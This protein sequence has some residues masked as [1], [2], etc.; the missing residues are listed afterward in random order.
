MR[1]LTSQEMFTDTRV[2]AGRGVDGLLRPR[3]ARADA[4]WVN[5]SRCLNVWGCS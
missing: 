4:A 1:T 2:G 5:V 3:V